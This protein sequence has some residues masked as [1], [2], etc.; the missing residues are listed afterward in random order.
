MF[1]RFV[2]SAAL[3]ACIACGDP[4]YVYD[5]AGPDAGPPRETHRLEIIGPAMLSLTSG[6]HSI[7]EVRLTDQALRP[8][9]GDEVRF[10]LEGRANDST[11]ETLEQT[12]GLDG[13]ARVT[14]VAGMLPSV[15]RVR[16][17]ADDAS[18]VFVDVSVSDEGFGRLS[19]TPVYE[20]EREFVEFG[21]TIF[22]GTTCEDPATLEES[23]D[24]YQAIGPDGPPVSFGGLPAGTPLTVVARGR[25]AMGTLLAW[26]CIDDVRLRD[27]EVTEL[28]VALRDRAQ[29]PGGSYR[30][31]TVLDGS[32]SGAAI[33]DEIR[34]MR[35]RLTASEAE[36][37]LDAAH[38]SLLAEGE[39]AAAAML[40]GERAAGLDD[41][42]AA[43]LGMGVG[44]ASVL[45]DLADRVEDELA[46][47]EFVGTLR[48][49]STEPRISFAIDRVAA[50]AATPEPFD[51]TR[52][53]L[54]A[55]ATLVATVAEDGSTLEIER[56]EVRLR[57]SALVRAVA[58]RAAGGDGATDRTT[59]FLAS[60]GCES[61]SAVPDSACDDVCLQ[62]ACA[63]ASEAAFAS[64][65]EGLTELDERRSTIVLSGSVDFLE[66]DGDLTVDVLDGALSGEWIGMTPEEPE[67]I[68]AA[69]SG[70][71]IVPPS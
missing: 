17:T 25:G 42:V 32:V 47:L 8:L 2:L 19:V 67:A 48:V 40:V 30:T 29:L 28:D 4:N 5:A 16:V 55:P 34:A 36:A 41:A 11:L 46:M 58:S 18:P 43:Q 33:A 64:F 39:D 52:T 26:G 53:G 12:T 57:S 22:S 6:E 20:G 7:I 27:M 45:T 60:V 56:L 38:A 61:L 65:D 23:G 9:A 63:A 35:D 44:V 24:R 68:D 21:V 13:S 66:T 10:A 14:L 50:G 71:R 59:W 31:S 1:L 3:L 69:F 15:Y 37:I 54:M 51:A 62:D 49:A 70:A